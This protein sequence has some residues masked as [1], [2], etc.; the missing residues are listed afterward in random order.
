[1]STLCPKDS[2]VSLRYRKHDAISH[3]QFEIR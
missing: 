1:V 2:M 3:R